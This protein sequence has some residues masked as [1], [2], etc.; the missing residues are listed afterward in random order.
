VNINCRIIDD[1]LPLYADNVCSAES[2]GL[3][4]E[5][6][7]ECPKCAKKLSLM[8]D[9]GCGKADIIPLRSV[10]KW[11]ER[12]KLKTLIKGVISGAL[13]IAFAVSAIF[14]LTQVAIMKVGADDVIISDIC[15]LPDGNIAFHLYIDDSFDLNCISA[16]VTG[17]GNMYIVP[18]RTIIENRRDK[19]FNQG[20]FNMY[21]GVEIHEFDPETGRDTNPYLD[22]FFTA[23]VEPKAVYLSVRGEDILI[24][25]KGMDLPPANYE[26]EKKFMNPDI[27]LDGNG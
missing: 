17:D 20:L 14:F 2:R 22:F 5:H 21:Y 8:N 10:G 12:L 23:G 9:T 11:L 4:E 19:D 15:E 26:V 27:N 7:K 24:W 16:N 3:V 6:I 18:Q 1:L 13:I 25:E